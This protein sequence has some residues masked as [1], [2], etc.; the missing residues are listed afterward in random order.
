MRTQGATSGNPIQD[1][2]DYG[3][4]VG[5]PIKKGRAWIWGSYRQAERRRRRRRLLPADAPR[6]RQIKATPRDR[7]RTPIEDVNGCLNTDQTLLQ[8]TNLKAR[9]AA[10]QGQQ[11]QPLQ[12]LSRRRSATRA[13]RA[14]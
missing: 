9:S 2:K 4:E 3:F 7:A 14:T 1:I 5:G 10:V 13:A 6:A 8:T 12:Q 11:A